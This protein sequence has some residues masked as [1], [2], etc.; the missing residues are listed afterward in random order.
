M[1]EHFQLFYKSWSRKV[2]KKK[3]VRIKNRNRKYFGHSLQQMQACRSRGL[4]RHLQILTDQFTLSQQVG[5]IMPT[6]L[7]LPPLPLI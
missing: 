5:Q 7:L 3:V 6:T 1:A 4:P 2:G